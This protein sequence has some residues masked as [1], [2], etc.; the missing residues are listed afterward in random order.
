MLYNIPQ[1]NPLLIKWVDSKLKERFSQYKYNLYCKS[2]SEHG[3]MENMIL[4]CPINIEP[5]DW[6]IF[7][8]NQNTKNFQVPITNLKY[9]N[10]HV[11]F[12]V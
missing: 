9:N 8:K 2:K 4:N 1:Q 3:T 10:I 6:E 12:E 7:I 11:I 5:E